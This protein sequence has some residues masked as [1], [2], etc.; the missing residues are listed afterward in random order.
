MLSILSFSKLFLRKACILKIGTW[1]KICMDW[2]ATT[3]VC[4]QRC[5]KEIRLDGYGR[6][7][8]HTSSFIDWM[9][10]GNRNLGTNT[11]TRTTLTHTHTKPQTT[12]KKAIIDTRRH[13]DGNGLYSP[14]GANLVHLAHLFRS[15]TKQA[16]S[17]GIFFFF[18][19]SFLLSVF[20]LFRLYSRDGT[21][22]AKL[23]GRI[24]CNLAELHQPLYMQRGGVFLFYFGQGIMG[25]KHCNWRCKGTEM[26]SWQ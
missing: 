9:E 22:G 23:F 24:S 18:F 10:N 14:P 4:T 17:A 13:W 16:F 19:F 11:N 26:S 15:F 12:K 7:R 8:R 3:S 21:T 6:K 1:K 25:T 20:L 2:A 5:P